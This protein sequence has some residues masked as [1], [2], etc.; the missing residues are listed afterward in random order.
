MKTNALSLSILALVTMTACQQEVAPPTEESQATEIATA[1]S[2]III[3]AD[4][5]RSTDQ[6]TQRNYV[7]KVG[8]LLTHYPTGRNRSKI[9]ACSATAINN[10]YIITAAHCA[11]NEDGKLH[12]NQYFYPG[13]NEKDTSPNGKF[14]VSKV[15]MPSM[16]NAGDSH[17]EY[18]IAIMKVENNSSGKSLGSVVGTFGY[19]GKDEYPSGEVFTIG[20][21]SDKPDS[22]QYYQAGCEAIQHNYSSNVLSLDCDVIK[23]QSG[24]PILVYSDEHQNYYVH[25]VVT[26]ESTHTNYGTALSQERGKI[27]RHIVNGTFQSESYKSDNFLESWKSYDYKAPKRVDVFVK[28]NCSSRDLYIATRYKTLDDEWV[29][30]GYAVIKPHKEYRMFSS[31]NGIYYIQATSKQGKTITRKDTYHYLEAQRDTVP[32][33]KYQVNKYGLFSHS[34]GCN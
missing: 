24:S 11:F 1:E 4:N 7:R 26:S 27:I 10:D 12:E 31:G 2:K 23:G 33:Q 19:W 34:Y 25:G 16:Y 15:Y 28:N 20:Y 21:P 30:E 22:K 5:R 17:P 8:Q 9:S 18:D 13:I 14:K 3:G 32:L 6:L 29:T